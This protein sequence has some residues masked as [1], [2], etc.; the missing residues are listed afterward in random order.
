MKHCVLSLTD[1]GKLPEDYHPVA[2]HPLPHLPLGTVCLHTGQRCS[3]AFT[4]GSGGQVN[5]FV[6]TMA[7][8]QPE[9]RLD[10]VM[11]PIMMIYLQ[12]PEELSE[13]HQV[14]HVKRLLRRTAA[15]R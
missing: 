4:A 2:V 5:D 11:T 8:T 9:L 1:F 13:Q 14:Q 7:T 6:V 10:D 15:H 12:G 3:N